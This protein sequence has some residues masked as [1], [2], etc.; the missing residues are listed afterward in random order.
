MKFLMAFFLWISVVINSFSQKTEHSNYFLTC[1]N[2]QGLNATSWSI[3][4]YNYSETY[5]QIWVYP[6]ILSV[7][8]L[9]IKPEYFN[10]FN[11]Q[12]ANL[13]YF[14]L[15]FGAFRSI[16]DYFKFNLGLNIPLGLEVLK[17]M[18]GEQINN[19]IMGV[20]PSQ[21]IYFISKSEHGI[22]FGIGV[23]EKLLTSLVYKSDF[24]I[25]AEVG[26]KF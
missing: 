22:I 5:K 1:S 7:E 9:K 3:S 26:I 15:G 24:G 10:R 2:L 17:K 21:N 18:D 13:N 4:Y 16:N 19:I 6:L 14:T 20:T 12:S 8:I 25:K 23:Y 11:Y